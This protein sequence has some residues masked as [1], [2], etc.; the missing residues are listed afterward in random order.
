MDW[1]RDHAWE[2]WLALTTLLAIAELVSL[3]LVL[4]MLAAGAGVGLVAA[5]VGLP[6]VVQV[7]LALGGAAAM[8]L[9]A[10][11][12]LVAR[13]HGGPELVL[14]AKRLVGETAVTPTEITVHQPVQL[15]FAGE[16]WSAKPYDE[17]LAIP[18]GSTVEVLEVRGAYAYVHPRAELA[19]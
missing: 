15:K 3:D 14:G 19:P 2:S 17:T 6:F 7:L 5:L 10:R 12:P 18:A 11:P 13:L 16:T 4:I 1:L 8:L 9:V